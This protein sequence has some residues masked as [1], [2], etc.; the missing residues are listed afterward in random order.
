[1]LIFAS[2][3]FNIIT[4]FKYL[5]RIQRSLMRFF[6]YMESMSL[7]LPIELI[8]TKKIQIMKASLISLNYKFTNRY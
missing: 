7:D 2:P 8:S 3:L 6:K 4:V 1:M 5:L